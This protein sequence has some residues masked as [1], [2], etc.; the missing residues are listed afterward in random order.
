M[1]LKEARDVIDNHVKD[2]IELCPHCSAKTHIEALWN[3]CHRLRNRDVE[4]YVI[5]R[6]KPCRRLILKTFY[7]RQ[8]PYSSEENLDIKGWDENFP[9]P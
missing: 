4:F 7:L 6:C 3:D 1:K 9:C 5:F 8:N 2:L